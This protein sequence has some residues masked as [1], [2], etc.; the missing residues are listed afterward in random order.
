MRNIRY[1]GKLDSFQSLERGE[2]PE[3]AVKFKEPGTM[4]RII[5]AATLV[6]LPVIV[7][8]SGFLFQERVCI[9]CPAISAHAPDRS[10]FLRSALCP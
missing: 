5:L 6:S 9:S 10:H 4:G 7:I 2:I 3:G 1:M 8:S